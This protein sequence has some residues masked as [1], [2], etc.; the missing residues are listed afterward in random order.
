MVCN[1]TIH[2]KSNQPNSNNN[3]APG[4]LAR[5]I[6]SHKL[7]PPS[8]EGNLVPAKPARPWHPSRPT[9]KKCLAHARHVGTA[10]IVRASAPI[11]GFRALAHVSPFHHRHRL[12]CS[13][14]KQYDVTEYAVARYS[15]RRERQ[16]D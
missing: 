11:G 12:H 14:F 3:G 9:P 6:S 7:N 4:A 2:S 16:V 15:A 5:R 10:P 13:C 8:Q 1:A